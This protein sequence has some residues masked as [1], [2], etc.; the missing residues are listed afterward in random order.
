MMSLKIQLDMSGQRNK[1][2][3]ESSFRFAAKVQP[4]NRDR[5]RTL[6]IVLDQYLFVNQ[7]MCTF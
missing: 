2:A 1:P 5:N 7:K 3:L 6:I 4:K